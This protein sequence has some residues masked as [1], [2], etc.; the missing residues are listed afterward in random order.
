[1]KVQ[2]QQERTALVKA[3]ASL[4]CEHLAQEEAQGHLQRERAALEGAQATLKLRDA[5][6]TRL[7]EELVQEGVFYEELRQAG[8]EKDATILELRRMAKTARASLETERKQVEGE[9]PFACLFL[10]D[11]ICLGSA[12]N[13][14]FL[15]MVFRP[16]QMAY[17][18]SQ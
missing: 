14:C 5:E 17:N 15:F 1:V 2:H 16:V 11:S 9:L 7:S 3:R 4:E 6:I 10:V 8:E 18:S 12:P 13:F